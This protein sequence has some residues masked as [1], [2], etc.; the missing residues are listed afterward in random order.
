MHTI[1]IYKRKIIVT[2]IIK[3]VDDDIIFDFVL[4][5]GASKTIIDEQIVKQLGY[6]PKRLQSDDRLMTVGG[7]IRS[8]TL[9]LPKLTLFGKDC[10]NFNVDVISMPLQIL[11]F[12]QGIIGMDFLLQ[13]ATVKFDFEKKTIEI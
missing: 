7:S 9:S 12:V 6:D 4:D 8:K 13:F 3:G 5:T 2:P 11:P 1:E 10:I